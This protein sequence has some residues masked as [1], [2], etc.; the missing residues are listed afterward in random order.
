LKLFVKIGGCEAKRDINVLKNIEVDGI[1][2]PMVETQF[3]L[4]KYIDMVKD[5]NFENIGFNVETIT[6]YQNFKEMSETD[7]FKSLTGVTVGR[8]DFVTSM[9]KNRSYVDSEEMLKYV[10]EVF[11]IAKENGKF[12]FLGGALSIKSKNFVKY[13]SDKGLLDFAETRSVV[14]DVR[15]LLE[16]FDL[17]LYHANVYEVLFMEKMRNRLLGPAMRNDERI[18][19]INDRIKHNETIIKK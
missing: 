15:K 7:I 18:I 12:T 3:A 17:S 19:M 1:V 4:K 2:A 13:L 16:N 8:V 5:L 14:F 9:G 11:T 6:A 10:E